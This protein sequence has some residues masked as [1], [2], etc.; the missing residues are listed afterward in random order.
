MS[1]E[2][3]IGELGRTLG[4][5]LLEPT[6][7]YVRAVVDLWN[8]GIHPTGLV[9]ITSDGFANLCRLDAE[10]GY[11]IDELPPIPSIF[12][13]IR[14]HGA[15]DDSEMYRVF[16]MGVGFVV[17][18]EEDELERALS[19]ITGS[20]YGAIRIGTVTDEVGVVSIGPAGMRGGLADGE[21]FF[22]K[23]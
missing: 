11:R 7:I 3:E 23:Y 1:L 5:E 18:V 10:V 8:A 20:G 14:K 16:N 12:E 22:E 2:D 9:H 17:I 13:L 15:I 4:D 19:S 21:S 6:E